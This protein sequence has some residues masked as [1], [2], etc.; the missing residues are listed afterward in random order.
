MRR[1]CAGLAAS[2]RC[3]LANGFLSSAQHVL[4]DRRGIT[5]QLAAEGSIDQLTGCL[6]SR[7]AMPLRT[8]A[9]PFSH[10]LCDM[11][12]ALHAV[13]CEGRSRVARLLGEPAQRCLFLVR[14]W[15]ERAKQSPCGKP[16]SP[17]HDRTFGQ[18]GN[19]IAAYLPGG[20]A[21]MRERTA[22]KPGSTLR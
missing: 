11:L 17:E 8:L 20:L 18:S 1:G 22:G 10:R 12:A 19:H 13:I 14:L 9:G 6:T 7:Q 15:D 16:K 3:F 5:S 4:D 2:L 21:A